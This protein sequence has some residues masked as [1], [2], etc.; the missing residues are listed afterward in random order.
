MMSLQTL[1]PDLREKL[2]KAAEV[3]V[4]TCFGV[5]PGE[6]FLVITDIETEVIGR[7]I[8]DVGWEVGA[9]TIYVVM[10]PRTRR[11]EEPPQ[12]IAEM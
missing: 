4:K 12:P 6:K 7:V 3:T 2:K 10:K 11:G 1:S 8:A 9:E 5:K